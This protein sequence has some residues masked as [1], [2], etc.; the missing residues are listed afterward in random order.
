[1]LQESK[2]L[3]FFMQ[4]R[5]EEA[6][7]CLYCL[8]FFWFFAK[9]GSITFGGG[10][11]MLPFLQR[12]VVEAR[13]WATNDELTDYYAVGQCTPGIIAVNTATFIGAKLAGN[14]GGIVA[15]LGVVFPSFVI[16]SLIA[17]F[18]TNFAELA[19]VKNAFAG[20]RICVCI[21]ILNAVLKLLKGAVVDKLT[22]ALFIIVIGISAFTNVSPATTVVVAGIIGLLAKKMR[23]DL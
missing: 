10:Y 2:K 7:I 15:T 6:L 17:A 4:N 21:L 23:G 20:I 14:I 18:L 16:I 12:E 3:E 5:R 13:H 22:G 11:A 9:I 1:M 8:N 19:V